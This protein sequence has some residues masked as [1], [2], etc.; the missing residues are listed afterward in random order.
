[1]DLHY[2]LYHRLAKLFCLG[3]NSKFLF[4]VGHM[5]IVTATLLQLSF[6]VI[7][8]KQ[9]HTLCKLVARAVFQ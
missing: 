8:Q 4:S 6:S 3:L 1:M 5:V 7:V 2:G 9:S